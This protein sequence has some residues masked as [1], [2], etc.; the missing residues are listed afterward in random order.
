M[1]SDYTSEFLPARL[2]PAQC[3][4]AAEAVVRVLDL[5]FDNAVLVACIYLF[6]DVGVITRVGDRRV[7]Q[8]LDSSQ[9]RVEGEEDFIPRREVALRLAGLVEAAAFQI[10]EMADVV[11]RRVSPHSHEGLLP[12]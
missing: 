10:A 9:L 2:L 7:F 5:D 3:V 6:D 1:K 4:T 8:V 12:L 11:Y